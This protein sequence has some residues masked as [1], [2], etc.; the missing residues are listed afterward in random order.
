MNHKPHPIAAR[1]LLAMA[2]IAV[3]YTSFMLTVTLLDPKSRK[4]TLALLQPRSVSNATP[5]VYGKPIEGWR[6]GAHTLGR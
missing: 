3:G 5:T 2:C 1:V 6:I 4:A